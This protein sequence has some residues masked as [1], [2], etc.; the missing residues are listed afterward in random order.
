MSL[1]TYQHVQQSSLMHTVHHPD[2]STGPFSY[3]VKWLSA[4]TQLSPPLSIFRCCW[5][6]AHILTFNVSR[7][8]HGMARITDCLAWHFTIFSYLHYDSA[9]DIYVRHFRNINSLHRDHVSSFQVPNIDG[10]FHI[11]LLS[12]KYRLHLLLSRIFVDHNITF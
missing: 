11:L 9:K 10:R 5:F 12:R 2:W 7:F 8:T 3:T 4:I 1:H 6:T